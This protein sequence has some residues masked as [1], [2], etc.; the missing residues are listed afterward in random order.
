MSKHNLNS[1]SMPEMTF[2]GF[3][4]IKN[5]LYVNTTMFLDVKRSK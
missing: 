1:N 3:F 2:N 5:F 4:T